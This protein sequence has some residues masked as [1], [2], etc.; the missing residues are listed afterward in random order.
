[1]DKHA[2]LKNSIKWLQ[3]LWFREFCLFT[4]G[5]VT[6]GELD[7]VADRAGELYA[8]DISKPALMAIILQLPPQLSSNHAVEV[9][10][11]KV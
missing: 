6:D 2:L 9:A 1:L 3:A 11:F 5:L 4:F 7:R 8:A 10:I